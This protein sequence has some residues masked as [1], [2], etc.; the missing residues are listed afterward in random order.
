VEHEGELGVVIRR[1]ATHLNDQ[2]DPLDYVFG[3]TCLNDV[4]ARD[5]QRRDIQFTRGKSFDT[6]CPVGPFVETALNPT[7]LTVTTR[8]NGK[9][10]QSG[11]TRDMAFDVPTLIR[12]ISRAMTLF[13]G[14]LIA[15]GTPA[16]VKRMIPGDTV[17]IEIGGIGIL[18]N[19]IAPSQD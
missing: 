2:D 3:Y 11:H 13:P 4:T 14:D 12:Y 1:R 10:T 19:F 18:R 5:I 16:G 15:T 17:E 6:F 9:I 7:D 8:L